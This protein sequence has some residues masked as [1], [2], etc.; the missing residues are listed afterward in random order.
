MN[1]SIKK[2]LS[3]SLTL[4]ITTGIFAL[5]NTKSAFAL[6]ELDTLYKNAFDSTMTALNKKTQD[7]INEARVNIGKLPASL[8][9]YVGELSKQV[10]TVQHPI[11]VNIVNS[12]LKAQKDGSQSNINTARNSI[13]KSLPVVWKNPYSSAIDDVQ[14]T[15]MN[16]A[17]V[18]YNKA[19]VTCTAKD[20]LDAKQIVSELK[21]V[22]N[23]TSVLNF[24]K[25][26]DDK[27]TK[28]VPAAT[29]PEKGSLSLSPTASGT[30]G[31]PV[32]ITY[33]PETNG[34]YEYKFSTSTDGLTWETIRNY[35]SSNTFRWFPLYVN[36]FTIKVEA[37]TVGSTKDAEFFAKSVFVTTPFTNPSVPGTTPNIIEPNYTWNGELDYSNNPQYIIL[38]H[39]EASNASA[40]T[41]HDW[42]KNGNGWAGIGY[43]FY[44]RK[45]GTIYRGRP[46]KAIGA[47]ALGY[48]DKS[49]GICAEGA[50]TRELMPEAQR[51]AIIELGKYIK[52]KYSI[53]TVYGHGEINSTDCP[54]PLYDL[55]GIRN[56][57]L[58]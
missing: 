58:K 1:K 16:K 55:N 15:L 47:H 41:I 52:D 6:S 3:L 33:K 27:I 30:V 44:V 48:N 36:N 22:E 25:D 7:S 17:M 13:P 49:I 53:K 5:S 29:V 42:H 54:G 35:S 10:D 50:Y 26:L 37:R 19:K 57:I 39:A 43:H 20:I 11:L 12:I 32:S 46:E 56:S 28:I 38:H 4:A 21:T 34:N 24:A 18:M 31:Q 51:K 14:Q 9:G 45:D 40:M 2:L 23:N 8:K